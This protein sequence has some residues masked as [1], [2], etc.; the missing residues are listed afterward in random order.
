MKNC[1]KGPLFHFLPLKM[2]VFS[3]LGKTESLYKR[4]K[5]SP[6]LTF[7]TS[8]SECVDNNEKGMMK[9][10]KRD[11]L[12]DYEYNISLPSFQKRMSNSN[13]KREIKDD[14]IGFFFLSLQK[15]MQLFRQ[16]FAYN[17]TFLIFLSFRPFSPFFLSFCLVYPTHSLSLTHIT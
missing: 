1:Q 11:L 13:T 5:H 15:V 17:C 10:G 12:V 16:K 14:S 7:K 4:R 8:L 6:H 9:N 2:S 3:F